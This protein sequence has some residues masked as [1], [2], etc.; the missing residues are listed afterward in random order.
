MQESAVQALS[1]PA[2]TRALSAVAEWER[3]D[4]RTEAWVRS[5]PPV[6]HCG[7]L[8]NAQKYDHLNVLMGLTRQPYMYAPGCFSS[9]TGYDPMSKRFGI[10][11][12]AAFHIPDKPS[13]AVAL[14]ALALLK[15]LLAEFS[16]AA[17]HDRA[18]ALCLLLTASIRSS[19]P[20][21]PMFHIKAPVQGSGKSYACKVAT[22][23]ATP[24]AAS[25]LHFPESDEECGKLLLAVFLK[26]PAVVEFDD[27]NGDIQPFSALKTAITE[28]AITGRILGLSK[29]ATV[30]TRTLLLSSGNNVDPVR[31]MTRRVLT[32]Q[33]DPQCSAPAQRL[34][35][36]PDLLEEVKKRRGELVSAAMTI[37]RAWVLAGSPLADIPPVASFGQW[38]KFCRHSLVWL[39]LPDPCT[40]MFEAMADDPDAELLARLMTAWEAAFGSR[41]CMT[42]DLI[43]QAEYD[44]K[45]ELAQCVSEIAEERGGFI[46]RKRLGRWVKR[47]ELRIVSDMRIKP[48]KN[49][50]NAS[51]W[52]VEKIPN[53]G[54]SVISVSSH[55][56]EKSVKTAEKTIEVEL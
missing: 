10:Y 8:F 41:V 5:D 21:A 19:L 51:A 2:L 56:K 33:L 6:R 7:V 42:R 3:Y 27:L 53:V 16:F 45:G 32:I 44:P 22:A 34:Y 49:G 17:D 52:S 43:E 28:E 50:R 25:P 55:E 20:H 38:S 47:H 14:A 39:G 18:A 9:N 4:G 23:F 26:S 37:I 1:A 40:R 54:L 13:M 36:R 46:N 48:E 30:S 24:A 31:D 29:D 11:D 15:G 12:G 35:T